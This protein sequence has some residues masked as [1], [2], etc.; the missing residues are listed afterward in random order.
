MGGWALV[1]LVATII[2]VVTLMLGLAVLYAVIGHKSWRPCQRPALRPD[3][4]IS[5]RGGIVT[6]VPPAD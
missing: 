2:S 4:Q 5:H 3:C 6:R 1:I